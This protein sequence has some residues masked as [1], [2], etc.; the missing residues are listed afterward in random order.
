V[1]G[2][3][4]KEAIDN[5]A[6]YFK[7]SLSCVTE[8]WVTAFQESRNLYKITCDPPANLTKRD[9]GNLFLIATQVLSAVPD[10][11]TAGQF[12]AKTREYSY[13]LVAEKSIAAPDIVAYHWHPNDSDLRTPHLH[14][15]AVPRAH[16]P[17]SRVCLEDFI[18][19]LIRYY[20]VRTKRLSKRWQRGRS[21]I[22]IRLAPQTP[23]LRPIFPLWYFI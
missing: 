21:N 8:S 13:R 10:P 7:E 2:K 12:K 16:F 14:V 15:A 6:R 4:P 17:T 18:E 20:D 1:P 23:L 5:F 19:M 22:R 3:S 11:N 9:G